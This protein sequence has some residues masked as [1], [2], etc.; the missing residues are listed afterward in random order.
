MDPTVYNEWRLVS[1]SPFPPWALALFAAGI[2]L[3]AWASLHALRRDTRRGRRFVLLGLRVLGGLALLALLLEPGQRLMQTTRVK[4][5]VAVLVDRSASM[6]FPMSP[7]GPTRAEAARSLLQGASREFEALSSRF[8]IEL[9][10]FDRDLQGLEAPRLGEFAPQGGATDLAGAL[11][12]A[13]AG[14]GGSAGRK[15]S[16]MVVLSDGADNVELAEGL[17][18]KAKAMLE[19][20]GVPVST[21]GFGAGGLRDVSIEKVK[22]DDFAFVRNTI[23]VVATV[24]VHGFDASEVQVSLRREGRVVATRAVPVTGDGSF[25]VTFS[26]APDQTGQFVYTV[27]TPVLEGEA[28]PSN[29]TRSFSLKVIRDRV[30]VLMVVGHPSWDVRFLRGLLKQDPNVDLISFYILR[31]GTD[32]VHA[33]D[34]ELSLIPFPVQEIFHDQLKTF[35][36]VV[37]QNFAWNDRSYPEM[38]AY[39]QGMRDYVRD[40]GALVMVGGENSFGEGGYERTALQEVLPVEPTGA[41]PSLDPF[42][43]RLT[44]EGRRHPVAA[45]AASS[46]GVE[47]AWAELPPLDGLNVTRARADARVLLEHPF[48]TQDGRNVPVVALGEYGRGRSMAVC[49]DATWAWAFGA[50]GAGS[51]A[52]VY[53]R[54]W[55]NAIRWLV[56]DPDLTPVRVAAEKVGVEPGEPIAV[57]VTARLPDY[58]PASGAQVELELIHADDG[59]SAARQR[60][61]TG[62]DGSA[63]IEVMPPRPGPYKLLAKAS[64]EGSGAAQVLGQGEDAVAVRAVGPEL[65]EATPR[66]GLL[67]ELAAQT[68]GVFVESP[69]SWPE[70]PLVDP[71]T[72]EVGRRKDVPIWDRAWLLVLLALAVGADWMLR[73]RWGY[74]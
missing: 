19:D 72:V 2:G 62:A 61:T 8:S 69:R 47:K 23:E 15:L 16:G 70:V 58:G 30:R 21:F 28:V 46:D 9:Y 36:L 50:A 51:N 40:G 71:E 45:V 63:R 52:R 13:A 38:A 33:G 10:A 29:N 31:S 44:A 3:A 68:G 1:L 24:G 53:D 59:R 17:T 18:P 14:G 48:L 49:T 39:I 26:F 60:A 6:G 4:N 5:R 7:G 20:L 37:L 11:R 25:P 64:I 12:A 41:A 42:V 57:V 54:L 65:S 32:N 34:N 67:K 27:E 22:V 55:T 73:R 74:V 66:P 56:R 43:A 35:D